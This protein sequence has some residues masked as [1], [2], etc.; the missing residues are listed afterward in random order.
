MHR[1]GLVGGYIWRCYDL[2]R[3]HG[4]VVRRAAVEEQALR[5]ALSNFATR[6]TLSA[7][8]RTREDTGKG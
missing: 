1:W 7:W 5:P 8:I 4:R 2:V 3:R 6:Q